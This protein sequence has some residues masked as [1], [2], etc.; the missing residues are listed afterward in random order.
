[1]V[2]GLEWDYTP[3]RVTPPKFFFQKKTCPASR[4]H[5]YTS[6]SRH[7]WRTFSLKKIFFCP[8]DRE[9][10]TISRSSLEKNSRLILA[11]LFEL[12]HDLSAEYAFIMSLP[13]LVQVSWVFGTMKKW[14][15]GQTMFLLTPFVIFLLLPSEFMPSTTFLRPTGCI[16]EFVWVVDVRVTTVRSV[17]ATLVALLTQI[18]ILVCFNTSAS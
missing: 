6:R 8:I 15:T 7:A 5:A 11:R 12:F 13:Y 18:D 17:W 1:M 2:F 14:E 16:A 3:S 4:R 10:N 9:K